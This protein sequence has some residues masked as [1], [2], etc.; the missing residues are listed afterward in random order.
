MS[1]LDDKE[2]DF[3][4]TTGDSKEYNLLWKNPSRSTEFNIAEF[5]FPNL[6]GTRVERGTPMGRKLNLELYF[7]GGDHLDK[8]KEFEQ[9]SYNKKR[10]KIQHPYYGLMFVQPV[11][12]NYDNTDDNVTK[13]TIPIIETILDE[14]PKQT[15]SV[16]D[17]IK[18]DKLI[19]DS[20]L[21]NE[22]TATLKQKDI[23]TLQAT[24]KKAY[25]LSVPIIKL[26][27]EFEG[28]YNAFNQAS[29]FINTAT[30]TPLLAMR[31]TIALLTYPANFKS[32]ATDRVNLLNTTFNE[33]RKTVA[34]S[35][36]VSSKQIYQVQGSA[37]ISAICLAS[38]TPQ[39]SDYTNKRVA[40]SVINAL[41]TSYQN[42]LYDLDLLQ[43]NNGGSINSFIAGAN[44]LI[45]LESLVYYTISNL[46]LIALNSKTERSII[47]EKDTNII[48]LTHRLYG[49]DKLD[50]NIDELIKNNNWGL[51]YLLQINKG[52]RVLYYT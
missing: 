47:T 7:V 2:I 41:L 16:L 37:I 33:L 36:D 12:I 46:Y 21:D 9:S 52:T 6:N 44:S 11:S 13:L 38:S 27:E 14:Y 50:K 43:S 48:L 45:Q 49:L 22:L 10:W 5:N 26:P 29:S 28:Y 4:I 30:A 51:N 1:W 34:N 18:Y 19:L 32:N 24:T 39:D 23:N 40:L 20:S 25:N 42:F 31:A 8:S 17:T 35:L 3:I 15:I